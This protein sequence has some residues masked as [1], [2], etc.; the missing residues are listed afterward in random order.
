[1]LCLLVRSYTVDTLIDKNMISR[2]LERQKPHPIKFSRTENLNSLP[3]TASQTKNSTTYLSKFA[4]NSPHNNP[5]GN[6]GGEKN[7]S[8]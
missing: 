2:I 1:M 6:S 4:N 8:Q 3:A 5:T 7:G